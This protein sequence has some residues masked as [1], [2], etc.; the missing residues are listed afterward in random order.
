MSLGNRHTSPK[1][2]CSWP[3]KAA[4][5]HQAWREALLSPS[6]APADGCPCMLCTPFARC[7]QSFPGA[8]LKCILS[9]IQYLQAPLPA[10]TAGPSP[11]PYSNPWTRI[12][13]LYQA[14]LPQAPQSPPPTPAPQLQGLPLLQ[15]ALDFYVSL[16]VPHPQRPSRRE[17]PSLQ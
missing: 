17:F 11:R 16:E 9:L 12:R 10:L 2:P 8:F 14:F 13:I 15:L 1:H 6:A 3:G 5:P 4:P 7:A